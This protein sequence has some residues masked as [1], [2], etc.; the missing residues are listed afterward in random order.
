MFLHIT[1][2]NLSLAEYPRPLQAMQTFFFFFF[3]L[4][5]NIRLR[6]LIQYVVKPWQGIHRASSMAFRSPIPL[7]T[8]CSHQTPFVLSVTYWHHTISPLDQHTYSLLFFCPL[9]PGSWL[10]KLFQTIYFFFFLVRT[11][12]NHTIYRWNLW[13]EMKWLTS[14]LHS[15]TPLSRLFI[16][17]LIFLITHW[18]VQTSSL[19]ALSSSY[20]FIRLPLPLQ[21]CSL[22]E[23]N[24]PPRATILPDLF[25]TQHITQSQT[26]LLT[27]K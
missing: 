3:N 15:T 24:V 16:H 19:P 8:F 21:K 12:Y 20:T 14:E 17:I 22:T 27:K 10:S 7:F 13:W 9:T 2:L 23:S 25:R 5:K 26:I 6:H 11:F 4:T 18:T 1:R